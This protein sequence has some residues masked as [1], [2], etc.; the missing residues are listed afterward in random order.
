MR[1]LYDALGSDSVAPIEEGEGGAEYLYRSRL[2][3]DEI[4]GIVHCTYWSPEDTVNWSIFSTAH[5]QWRQLRIGRALWLA[6]LLG[7][8]LSLLKVII[9]N[10]SSHI[11]GVNDGS[12]FFI[13]TFLAAIFCRMNMV[14]ISMSS[15][16]YRS[17]TA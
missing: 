17:Q 6:I 3:D 9:N 11:N 15:V 12:K 16:S 10:V 7:K 14:R 1:F 13:L 2:G 5:L 4:T 8:Q